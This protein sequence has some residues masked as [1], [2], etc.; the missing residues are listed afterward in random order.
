MKTS[1]PDI[2]NKRG[3]PS[4]G[5]R[6]PGIMVRLRPEDLETLDAWRAQGPGKTLSRPEAIR[7]LLKFAMGDATVAL[8]RTNVL[9]MMKGQDGK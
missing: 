5:G 9:A 6:Q 8:Q 1:I 3:R 4:T 2:P 7:R